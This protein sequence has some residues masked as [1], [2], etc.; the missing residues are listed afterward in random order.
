ME[1]RLKWNKNVSAT[2][3][4]G[5][6]SDV[7]PC[8]TTVWASAQRDGRPAEYRWRPLFNAAKFGWCP[9][10]ECRA[11]TLPSRVTRWNL[12]GCPKL[13]NRSQPLVGRS[14][15]YCKGMW[16]RYCCLRSFFPIVNTC[17]SCEDMA[18]QSCAMV[19]RWGFFASC[20]STW[21][22]LSANLECMSKMCC[23]R[24]TANAGCKKIAIFSPSH[25]F[26]R[27]YLHS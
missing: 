7:V 19:R 22:G 21:C 26:V 16:R 1:P 4:F 9:L 8:K 17:F 27:P 20:I 10:L 3:T 23:M 14:S 15:P 13:A 2:K 11:V 18:R 6:I 5:S 25:N 12:L 24:L